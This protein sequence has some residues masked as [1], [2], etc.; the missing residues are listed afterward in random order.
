MDN[1]TSKPIIAEYE[2]SPIK[3]VSKAT[4]VVSIASTLNDSANNMVLPIIPLFL[5]A[6]LGASPTTI[7][8]IEGIAGVISSLFTLFPGIWSDRINRRTP[9]VVGGYWVSTFSR[10]MM[11]L[12]FSWWFI[13]ALRVLDR[14]G[15]SMRS[16]A[17][18]AMISESV[19]SQLLGRNFGFYN[20]ADNLGG[21]IG[22]LLA[23]SVLFLFPNQFRLVFII[24]VVPSILAVFF[25]FNLRDNV[26]VG[27]LPQ[28]AISLAH[29]REMPKP[30]YL[31]LLVITL[32]G[33]ANSS[34]SFL[35]LRAE[36]VGI[37]TAMI[38]LCIALASC[39]AMLVAY[40]AGILADRIGSL[41]MAAL[42]FGCY[43]LTYLGFAF[44][45]LMP[46]IFIWLFFLFYGGGGV[47]A[48]A[49]KPL[50]MNIVPKERR[51][52][53]SGLMVAFGGIAILIGNIVAG[54][55]WS[56]YNSTATFLFGA[57]LATIALVTLLLIQKQ[58]VTPAKPK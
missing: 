16:S 50:I 39:T 5:V 31:I 11:F 28:R 47:I 18:D 15:R 1:L 53:A 2:L 41:K 23:A 6:T 13:L 58:I 9:F 46:S 25:L 22:P 37:P 51:A 48:G 40:P 19:P 30:F 44:V 20:A 33:L 35:V 36:Q 38:P 49:F 54:N 29:F 7:G 56:L 10:T 52:T 42:G 32:F 8:L 57:C 26:N 4:F 27:K 43:A 55:L 3:G 24:A 34:D 12:A 45:H 14:F 21:L 17:R